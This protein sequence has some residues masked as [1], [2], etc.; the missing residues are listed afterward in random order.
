MRSVLIAVAVTAALAK[1]EAGFTYQTKDEL[2]ASLYAQQ[3]PGIF[4]QLGAFKNPSYCLYVSRPVDIV[5][6]ASIIDAAEDAD[7][8]LTFFTAENPSIRDI[9][10][11]D[12]STI[13]IK[14]IP[15]ATDLEEVE[16]LRTA[17]FD[18]PRPLQKFGK[19]R[20]RAHRQQVF[21]DYY[22]T[23][24]A[25]LMVQRS[26]ARPRCTVLITTDE[27]PG[28][29]LLT[30]QALLPTVVVVTNLGD[31]RLPSNPA[32][33]PPRALESA[34]NYGITDRFVDMAIGSVYHVA[35]LVAGAL[36]Y[37]YPT[38][39]AA[40]QL[41]VVS[42]VP[43]PLSLLHMPLPS[44]FTSV[45]FMGVPPAQNRVAAAA[46]NYPLG[47]LTPADTVEVESE[48]AELFPYSPGQPN[49]H[50][51]SAVIAAF[52]P[53]VT[54]KYFDRICSYL[55]RSSQFLGATSDDTNV[56]VIWAVAAP[57]SRRRA[58]GSPD[59]RGVEVAT[60]VGVFA[61]LNSN[62]SIAVITSGD[63]PVVAT[64][65][66]NGVNVFTFDF[67]RT[68]SSPL[69]DLSELEVGMVFDP[70]SETSCSSLTITL[71][72]LVKR[73]HILIAHS[74]IANFTA[75][76][77]GD[78]D[79]I[80]GRL[81]G[82]L[83]FVEGLR[84]VLVP[85][86][87]RVPFPDGISHLIRTTGLV[88]VLVLLAYAF[89]SLPLVFASASVFHYCC[90]SRRARPPVRPRAPAPATAAAEPKDKAAPKSPKEA[91]VSEV[92]AESPTTQGGPRQ[93]KGA[94]RDE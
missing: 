20:Y 65:L 48:W 86:A 50:R 67:D 73:S 90:G 8:P 81:N 36:A 1:K 22:E 79:Q 19:L 40:P 83:R 53:D 70:F 78:A 69:R 76:T 63:L 5:H 24:R 55:Q 84:V 66:A 37:D 35:D 57:S 31:G 27:E 88:D 32:A 41:S 64:A 71:N 56:R 44:S 75:A 92:A 34:Y 13:T 15:N 30:L 85:A 43:L 87:L 21:D 49:K 62:V 93:R 33:I 51:R 9:I 18:L 26:G 4:P 61:L 42:L 29:A 91:P 16:R 14:Q 3:H 2:K 46:F 89:L 6:Y 82:L 54:A 60:A 68:L 52:N 7:I 77:I 94:K 23:M 28:V 59:C 12:S 39:H 11:S 10:P 25:N 38:S 58:D 74:H 45:G 17:Y 80:H 72:D 47:A